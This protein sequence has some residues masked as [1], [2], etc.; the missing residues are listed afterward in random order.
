MTKEENVK[1]MSAEEASALE[2]KIQLE[3]WS[4]D[5]FVHPDGRTTKEIREAQAKQDKVDRQE[6]EDF[7]KRSRL[8]NTPQAEQVAIVTTPNGA[9]HT[10]TVS[11]TPAPTQQEKADEL[12]AQMQSEELEGM[13]QVGEQVPGHVEPSL[14]PTQ[15]T[16]PQPTNPVAVNLP[17]GPAD[18]D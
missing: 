17:V 18:R 2:R 4:D 14:P 7:D 15:P 5:N 12:P 10:T 6:A 9:I 16:S 8:A 1:T 13:P 11:V 3:G